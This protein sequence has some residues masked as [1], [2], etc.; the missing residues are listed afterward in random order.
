MIK[1]SFGKKITKGIKQNSRNENLVEMVV[2]R[3]GKC[4]QISYFLHPS[5]KINQT[6][7]YF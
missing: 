5:T 7:C 4:S 6:F 1:K 2:E 3:F